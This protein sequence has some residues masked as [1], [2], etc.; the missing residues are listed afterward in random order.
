MFSCQ[1]SN[2]SLILQSI[3]DPMIDDPLFTTTSNDVQENK[4]T[5]ETN[6]N[7][8]YYKSKK[9]WESQKPNSW[10]IQYDEFTVC[11]ITNLCLWIRI[12]RNRKTRSVQS[13]PKRFLQIEIPIRYF[14]SE[15]RIL[16]TLFCIFYTKKVTSHNRYVCINR[17]ITGIFYLRM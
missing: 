2:I 3:F 5:K 10:P 1:S 12:I 11:I 13:T 7:K 16:T 4:Y 6:R 8:L 14:S 17:H 9:S 15:N